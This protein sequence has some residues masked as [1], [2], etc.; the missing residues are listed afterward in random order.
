MRG[1]P[2]VEQLYQSQTWTLPCISGLN[3]RIQSLLRHA[4]VSSL[5][6]DAVVC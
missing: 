3:G 6:P 2:L 4:C 5:D 1:Q